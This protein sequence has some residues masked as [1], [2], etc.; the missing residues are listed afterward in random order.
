MGLDEPPV[1][2][3]PEQVEGLVLG[4]DEHVQP[5][6]ENREGRRELDPVLY[7][8]D[9]EGRIAHVEKASP[10]TA[11]ADLVRILERLERD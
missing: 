1:R 4:A 7:R 5:R 8:L 11:G 2:L 3:C 9:R 10:K 6:R